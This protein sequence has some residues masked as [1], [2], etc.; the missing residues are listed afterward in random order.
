MVS[1]N[2]ERIRSTVLDIL[3]YAKDREPDWEEVAAGDVIAEVV[4]VMEI[5]AGHHGV[6][7]V[8]SIETDDDRFEAD[9]AALRAMLINLV[10]N[11]FDACRVD[12]KKD[13][14]RVSL[15]VRGSDA[16]IQVEIRDNGIGMPQDIQDKAFTLFFS[17]KGAGG[18][19]LGLFI[20]NK[21]AQAHG[22]RIDLESKPDHGT[23]FTV[24]MPRKRP[25][26]PPTAA[27]VVGDAAAAAAGTNDGLF[28]EVG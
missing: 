24:A 27:A 28:G 14:H 5:K 13:A 21:I 25:E 2:V 26:P 10:D 3:Y 8:T 1:R 4:S 12:T 16:E 23:C 9:Q 7:L 6:E 15:L 19:G 20:A 18:T 17:S 11:S 22:G